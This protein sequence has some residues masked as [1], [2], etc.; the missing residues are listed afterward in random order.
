MAKEGIYASAFLLLLK[1]RDAWINNSTFLISTAGLLGSKP[2]LKSAFFK[3]PKVFRLGGL[4]ESVHLLI[5]M[6]LNFAMP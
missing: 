4:V 6:L 3:I 5:K 1:R 2:T